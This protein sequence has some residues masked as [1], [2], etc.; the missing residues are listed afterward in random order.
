[1][2]NSLISFYDTENTC[3]IKSS[4]SYLFDERGERY[5]DFE[6]GDWVVNLG[7]SHSKINAVISN[8]VEILFHDG[9]AFRSHEAEKLS[10]NLQQKL[11]MQNGQS[12]FLSSGS[13]AVNLGITIAKQLTK[14]SKVLKLDCSYLAAYGNGCESQNQDLVSIKTNEIEAIDSLVFDELA[15]FVFES[16]SSSGL[17]HFP[18]FEFIDKLISSLRKHDVLI[19]VNEVTTGL[20]R[21]GKWFGFQHYDIQPDIV[22]VGKALGNGYPISGV[23]ISDKTVHQF[24]NN[25]FRYAQSHQNDSMGCR[26]GNEVLHILDSEDIIEISRNK[27]QYFKKFLIELQLAH[28]SVIKEVRGKGLML[29]IEFFEHEF[30]NQLYKALFNNGFV[31][32]HKSNVIRFMPPLLIDRNDIQLLVE[33]ID[34]MLSKI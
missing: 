29:A 16:G 11:G 31:V 19:M 12:V 22:A 2:T 7:H 26:I 34:V 25:K 17:I 20:G 4:G 3:L 28:S 5:I 6:S 15:V 23:V 33:T 27:G 30:A 24:Q 21:T 13:E 8:Q 9:I 14:R 32:G 10:L 1:M 18:D